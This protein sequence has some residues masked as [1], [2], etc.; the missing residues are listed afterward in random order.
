MDGEVA[1]S[2]TRLVAPMCTVYAD[3]SWAQPSLYSERHLVRLSRFWATA[4]KT[5]RPI[6]SDRCPV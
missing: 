2:R 6:L 5:V 1:A 4:G 3:L